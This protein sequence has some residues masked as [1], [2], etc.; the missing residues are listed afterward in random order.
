MNSLSDELMEQVEA[1]VKMIKSYVNNDYAHHTITIKGAKMPLAD[2]IA[3]DVENCPFCG[4]DD[5]DFWDKP[6]SA[7]SLV[8]ACYECP[9]CR[10]RYLW[11]GTGP[12]ASEARNFILATK[13]AKKEWNEWSRK[14]K[15]YL[16]QKR[17]VKDE[18][19][20]N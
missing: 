5:L 11:D 4:T 2:F 13:K 8:K 1:V 10:R 6:E 3:M 15:K 19:P 17:E 18:R 9:N 20:I 14:T 12:K 7:G 16:K